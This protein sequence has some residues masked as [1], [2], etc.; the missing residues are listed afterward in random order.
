[1]L[2]PETLQEKKISEFVANSYI[3]F[4]FSDLNDKNNSTKLEVKKT[5]FTSE[6]LYFFMKCKTFI[7]T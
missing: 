6:R 4:T 2:F 1:M 5:H 3:Y 7:Q